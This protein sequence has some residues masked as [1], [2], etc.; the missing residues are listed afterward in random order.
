MSCTLYIV[1]GGLLRKQQQQLDEDVTSS[2]DVASDD[3]VREGYIVSTG[4]CQIPDVDLWHSS[5]LPYV[6]K[7]TPSLSCSETLTKPDL[8]YVEVVLYTATCSYIYK[9]LMK[10]IACDKGL[11]SRKTITL[12]LQS[13]NNKDPEMCLNACRKPT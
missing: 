3:E 11:P 9:T 5:V 6:K 1:S 2:D 4:H 7:N 10:E 8:T 12:Y 13:T